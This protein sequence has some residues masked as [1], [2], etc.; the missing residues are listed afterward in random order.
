MHSRKVVVID[1]DV[2]TL[3]AIERILELYDFIVFAAS[4]GREGLDLVRRTQPDIILCD[5]MMPDVD[6]Y[7][8]LA[9]LRKYASTATIPVLMLSAKHDLADIRAGMQLGADDF[10]SKPF[11]VED[12][13]SSINTRLE[14]HDH[15]VNQAT[16][17]LQ[18]LRLN[19]AL[20]LPHEFRT[21]LNSI[22]GFGELLA[23]QYERLKREEVME[24]LATI[25]SS[26]HRLSGLV[27]NF[28][29]LSRL[30]ILAVNPAV[31]KELIADGV[32]NCKDIIK[33]VAYHQ[34]AIN[35]SQHHLESLVEAAALAISDGYL[36][37][38]LAEL[39]DNACKFS[40]AK[41][42][43]TIRG[44]TQHGMYT[45]SVQDEGRGIEAAH[46][47]QIGAYMQFDRNIH[48]QQ[49][50][51]LG[52]AIAKRITELHGGSFTIDSIVGKGTTIELQLPLAAR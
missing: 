47:A 1:D 16:Q 35:G 26:G 43:I 4:G 41:S 2:T 52:L 22:I 19:I 10:L 11:A 17:Q 48:E 45:L 5:V 13:L 8:V 32:M 21:P 9:E 34:V 40:L 36:R 23:G 38:L 39:V 14:R 42:N 46:I 12:L 6:G 15:L 20:V 44:R 31:Q 24:M 37:K 18:Q 7:M 30:E 51:G 3:E 33:E 50:Q 29:Y 27:E 28:I 49:G 25:V